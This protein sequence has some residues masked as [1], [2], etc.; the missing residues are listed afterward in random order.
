MRRHD[1]PFYI[2]KDLAAFKGDIELA[3]HEVDPDYLNVPGFGTR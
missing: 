1:K 2:K 3:P